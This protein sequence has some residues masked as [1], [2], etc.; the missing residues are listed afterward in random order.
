MASAQPSWGLGS[1]TPDCMWRCS[2]TQKHS[3]SVG[4]IPSFRVAKVSNFW[5]GDIYFSLK[6]KTKTLL[7]GLN[8]SCLWRV[9][10][11]RG[12]S[13]DSSH[14]LGVFS[15]G[16]GWFL[17]PVWDAGSAPVVLSMV[18]ATRLHG[19]LTSPCTSLSQRQVANISEPYILELF[20][21]F[22]DQRWAGLRP[23]LSLPYLLNET[24]SWI[25]QQCIYSLSRLQECQR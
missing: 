5:P 16:L 8:S 6:C 12:H 14:Y 19:L 2:W 22:N 13:R 20:L 21:D 10:M 24:V 1:H 23:E 25:Y 3:I 4:S 9:G 17:G 7:A 15:Q 18:R 11:V